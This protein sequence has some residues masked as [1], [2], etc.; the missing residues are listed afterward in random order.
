MRFLP[1][2]EMTGY[3]DFGWGVM[4]VAA[5]PPPSPP[6]TNSLTASHSERREES[7]FNIIH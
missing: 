5:A 2:V 6:P 1:L 7:H 3:P 4:E